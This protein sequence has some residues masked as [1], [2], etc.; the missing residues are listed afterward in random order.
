MYELWKLRVRTEYR[1]TTEHT[2]CYPTN[3]DCGYFAVVTVY[4]NV[5]VEFL[6][7]IL[8]ILLCSMFCVDVIIVLGYKVGH[9]NI[10]TYSVCDI[11]KMYCSRSW[12][13]SNF[14]VTFCQ[15]TSCCGIQLF[16][17]VYFLVQ[18]SACNCFLHC[19]ACKNHYLTLMD[20]F[21]SFITKLRMVLQCCSFYTT[22]SI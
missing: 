8:L 17:F 11:Q 9:Q 4:V 22:W 20:V 15:C 10:Q 16:M 12:Q 21:S 7:W 14:Y 5:V 1:E 2:F 3:F 18:V 19:I 13:Y 6:I